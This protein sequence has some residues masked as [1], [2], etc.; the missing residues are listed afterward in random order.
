MVSAMVW[1]RFE[2]GSALRRVCP[3]PANLLKSRPFS[4]SPSPPTEMGFRGSRVQIP[5]SRLFQLTALQQLL[6]AGP[7][8]FHHRVVWFRAAFQCGR[9]EV[10]GHVVAACP[11]EG[12][13]GLL[14]GDWPGCKERL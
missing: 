10:A 7:N 14:D 9:L 11:A 5:P 12:T 2:P 13:C 6:V 3:I 8:H 4:R 1:V